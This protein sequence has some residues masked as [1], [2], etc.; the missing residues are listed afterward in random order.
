MT[1]SIIPIGKALGW[2]F[3]EQGEFESFEWFRGDDILD[4]STDEG[5]ALTLVFENQDAH[6][7]RQ[8]DRARF[9]KVLLDTNKSLVD[10]QINS[11]I[12]GLFAKKILAEVDV[13]GDALRSF[14]SQYRIIPTARS[15]GNTTE[16]PSQF[17]IGHAEPS[18]FFSG[19]SRTVWMLS[20]TDGSI[21]RGC[22]LLAENLHN[23]T[24]D[25]VAQEF[26]RILPVIVATEC[27]H[28]EVA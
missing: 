25:D 4:L 10:Q 27:G 2:N 8:F 15:F 5:A 3:N 13:E 18:I 11:L 20:H 22:E 28:L 12:N 17:S 9:R 7:Q 16:N 24:A 26:A 19:W 6:F 14:F 23:N 21:W 1:K